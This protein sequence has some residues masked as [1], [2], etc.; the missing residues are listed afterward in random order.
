[1]LRIGAC[2]TLTMQDSL[3]VVGGDFKQEGMLGR[4]S[5][6]VPAPQGLGSLTAGAD[7]LQ[8]ALQQVPVR[9]YTAT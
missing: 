5:V 8:S 7:L 2:T 9:W 3:T 4:L 6:A 1:M